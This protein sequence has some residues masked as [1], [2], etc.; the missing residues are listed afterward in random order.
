M[1]YYL[2]LQGNWSYVAGSNLTNQQATAT[3]PGSRY[4]ANLWN[5]APGTAYISGGYGIYMTTAG[6]LLADTYVVT[7]TCDSDLQCNS[8]G[9]CFTN[10]SCQCESDW[11]GP[12][13]NTRKL[14]LLLFC[15]INLTFSD[16][17]CDLGTATCLSHSSCNYV[18]PNNYTCT[19]NAGYS[20]NGLT[21]C[22]GLLY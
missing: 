1:W 14:S 16:N 22:S 4:G 21:G 11:G 18:Y 9:S 12:Y 3:F 13:C 7:Y 19:C 5:L 8:H 20:G 17:E 2:P 15:E 10:G 6:G